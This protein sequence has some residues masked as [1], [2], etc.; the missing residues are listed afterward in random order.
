MFRL[1]RFELDMLL[2]RRA[3][4]Q[5][6][7][8][9]HAD[10]NAA[11]QAELVHVG[12]QRG[13][14]QHGVIKLRHCEVVMIGE[15]AGDCGQSSNGLLHEAVGG[16]HV[17]PEHLLMHLRPALQHGADEGNAEATAFIAH[18]RVD[19]GRLRALILW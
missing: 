5:E 9:Q 3:L 10:G 12:E 1:V 15:V 13:L 14:T 7:Q 11:E 17:L 18:K 19:A 8:R 2:H 4:Q 6:D 16:F